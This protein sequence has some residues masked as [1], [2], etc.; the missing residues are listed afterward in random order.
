MP[1]PQNCADPITWKS[2]EPVWVDQWPLTSDKL[3]ATQQLVQEQLNAGH[4]VNST[5]PWNTPI[6]VIRKKS[7]RWRLLQDL[8][9]VNAT[10]VLMGAL[11]PG[12]PT[13]V[14]IPQGYFKI[15]I[16]LKDCF[17]TIPL[18]PADQKRFAFSVPS[19]NFREPMKRYQWRVLPQGMAN[20]P[21]LCQK[22]VAAA[23][24]PVR[25]SWKSMYIVHY[26]DDILIAGQ[27]GEQTLSCFAHLKRLLIQAG[28]QI[29]PE[30]IQL[31]DPYTYLGFQICGPKITNRNAAIR[32]D[33]LKTLNDYQKLLGDI[34]W[35]RPYLKLTTG[36]LK[37]LF[38]ILKG[39]A[40]PQSPREMTPAASAALQRVEKAIAAQFVTHVNYS[41][42]L[43]FIIFNTTVTPTGLFWQNQPLMW[44][45]LPSSPKKVIL[46]YYDAVAD[47]IMLGREDSR[48]YFGIEPSK[49]IQPYSKS[50]IQW[51]LQ[52][53][54]A[55]PIA[56]ASYLGELD[57]HYPADRLIQFCK[58]HAFVFPRIVRREPLQDAM[59]VFTDGSSSGVAAYTFADST[60]QFKTAQSSAQLVELQAII[61]VLSAFPRKPLNIYTDSAYLAHSIPLLETA[62]QIKHISETAKLF[63]QC[64]Q[65]IR[66]RTIPFFLGHIRA[67]TGLPGPL[68]EGNDRADAATK[69]AATAF[70]DSLEQ[71][72][73]AHSLHH[74]N[75]QSLRLMYNITREQTRQIIKQCGT[76]VTLLPVP[77][78]GVN[79]RGLLP[80]Q[81]WQ[82]DVTHYPE[83]GNLKYL[84]I[85]IDTYS[86]FLL[87]SLQ[88]EKATKH[89]I[90]HLHCFSILGVPQ[91]IK[92]N[93]G[94]NYTTRA[95]RRFC[96][97]LHI[98]HITGIPYNPQGQGMVE[99]AHLSIKNT[100][101]KTKK[102]EW[103]P[104]KGTP[105][106]LLNHTLF[107]LNFLTLD[108][109]GK[110]AADCFWHPETH[111]RV[112]LVKW[113]D[114]MD[115]SWHGPDPVLI[116]GRG[117][118]CVFS[119]KHDAARWLP[120]RLVRQVDN[121]Y[122][123]RDDCAPEQAS[124]LFPQDGSAKNPSPP[125]PP[126]APDTCSPLRIRRP[127]QGT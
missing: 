123:A 18:H 56:C 22:Y 27:S 87:T 37:P 101:F 3:A 33:Q 104:T 28:L 34:N 90:A 39:D 62:A 102:G 103:Y 32:R 117:S 74:L 60:V 57:N 113:K 46:P 9:A 24:Q 42:P 44:I 55:W 12:L 11:Q 70:I 106:N 73:T 118:V 109:H 100:L 41:M 96:G 20:S 13:P 122:R 47:L 16:D 58:L 75:A 38:D 76:C 19:T 88:S 52:N 36:E 30:K 43:S 97:Q 92:T 71:A 31:Q 81:L 120:K 59:L 111:T 17:F 4:I 77:H 7:G 26:M 72:R 15:I 2:D 68:V 49:I 14:A 107:I 125:C 110:S 105:R 61:A 69:L 93:N 66:L 85:S 119:Q 63:L 98:T 126:V 82:M 51:L 94:P 53:T 84:H 25:N 95:F 79:P 67:H 65:L 1:A 78:L 48:K 91:Q 80:N 8:R 23:I 108:A 40:N 121:N 64:Q 50:Q 45:H 29:A 114:P 115:N 54:E 112:A 35:L 83:F 89:V 99:R 127:A 124:C 21:T 6:F 5:S 10:M 86:G 116:W